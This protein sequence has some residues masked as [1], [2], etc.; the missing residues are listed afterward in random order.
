M[1]R[2]IF[3]G[4][5]LFAVCLFCWIPTAQATA[6]WDIALTNQY[7]SDAPFSLVGQFTT[8]TTAP[9]ERNPEPLL[10]FIGTLNGHSVSLTPLGTDPSFIYDNLFFGPTDTAHG[11]YTEDAFDSGGVVIGGVNIYASG[12][13]VGLFDTGESEA[14]TGNI[15]LA[16]AVPEL[17][18]VVLVLAALCLLRPG[19]RR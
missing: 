12:V 14:L 11:W 2:T 7:S 9:L 4:L 6:L 16:S 8:A 10:S 1:K 15:T 18:A 13:L 17:P 5:A 3:L 19:V